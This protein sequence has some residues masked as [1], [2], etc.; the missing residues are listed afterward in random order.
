MTPRNRYAAGLP[1]AAGNWIEN[2]RPTSTIWSGT[3]PQTTVTD[4]A[5]ATRIRAV[6]VAVSPSASVAVTT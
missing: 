6:N 4:D 3:A 5:D 2:A 1:D